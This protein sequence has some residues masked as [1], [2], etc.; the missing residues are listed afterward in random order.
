MR[1]LVWLF[2]VIAIGVGA[3][4]LILPLWFRYFYFGYIGCSIAGAAA[5]YGLVELLRAA[6]GRSTLLPSPASATALVI[7]TVVSIVY[8]AD[9]AKN[10]LC[11]R[12]GD[13]DCEAF[14]RAL[15][16]RLL[17]IID[18]SAAGCTSLQPRRLHGLLFAFVARH[19]RR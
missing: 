8:L 2:S 12:I 10:L 9:N 19:C 4:A 1:Y 17:Q 14:P 16:V 15:T 5:L 11:S 18:S 3:A 13:R 7:M 6:S